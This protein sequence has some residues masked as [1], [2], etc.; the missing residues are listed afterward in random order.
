[1]NKIVSF[2]P[3]ESLSAYIS[4]YFYAINQFD[5]SANQFYTPKGTAAITIPLEINPNSY[6]MYPDKTSKIYFEKFVPF[7][8]GQM[9]KLGVSEIQGRF[10]FFVIVFTPIGLFHFLDGPAVQMTDRVMRLDRL[11]LSELH[12]KLRNLFE[13]HTEIESCLEQVNK[14]L[15][16]HFISMPKKKISEF[17]PSVIHQIHM[18]KGIVNLESLVE[19]LGINNRTFQLHFKNVIGI[20]PKLFCRITR[21]N[22]LLQALDAVPAADILDFAVQFG[23]ADKPHLYKDFKEFVGMT[24]LKYL[25]LINNVNA[26]VEKEVRNK[27]SR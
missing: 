22:F 14:Y 7:L 25:R 12:K 2:K 4:G 27:L 26:I 20:S 18:K 5:K 6:L 15:I 24:P 16:D 1:M 9:S 19:N 10:D 17:I 21:F 23:Y 8:F 13:T 3:D 11:G